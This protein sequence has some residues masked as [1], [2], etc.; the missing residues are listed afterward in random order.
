MLAQ[1]ADDLIQ[2]YGGDIDKAALS[3]EFRTKGLATIEDLSKQSDALY[4]KVRDAIPATTKIKADSTVGY[5][6]NKARELGGADALSPIERRTLTMLSGGTRVAPTDPNSASSLATFGQQKNYERVLP[7]Y[8]RVD[9]LRKQVGEGLRGR[10]AF[11][12]AESGS[13]KQLYARLSDDQQAAAES[14]GAGEMFSSAKQLVASRKAIEDNL[15]AVL[16][17]DLS[18]AITAKT[19]SAIKSLGTGNY[20]DFDR[21]MKAIPEDQRKRVVMTSL[22]DAFTSGSR[23]EKQLSAPGFVD[24]FEGLQRN[25]QAKSRLY[26]NMPRGSRGTLEN[27]YRVARGMREA[28]KERITTGRIQG[29]MENFANEGG[30]LAKMYGIGKKIAVAEGAGSAIGVPGAGTAGV[31]AQVMGKEKTPIMKAADSLLASPQFKSALDEFAKSG[32]SSD[33]ARKIDASLAKTRAYKEWFNKLT[34]AQQAAVKSN[35]ALIWLSQPVNDESEGKP[36]K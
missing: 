21:I 2:T 35:G 25:R 14:L 32:G 30:M 20:R 7:T 34:K 33:K 28:S 22:N 3:S 27:I 31:I 15:T 6:T 9:Q 13:L 23:M 26:A 11:K 19:G 5:L 29:L 12:D 16:G 1:R 36:G 8:A 4:D 18:G 10:G 24:W 17:K